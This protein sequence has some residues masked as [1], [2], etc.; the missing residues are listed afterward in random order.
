MPG[1][2]SVKQSEQVPDMTELTDK[3]TPVPEPL[4]SDAELSEKGR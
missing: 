2:D 4:L 1:A 3:Q